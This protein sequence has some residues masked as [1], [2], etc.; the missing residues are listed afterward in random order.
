MDTAKLHFLKK[1]LIPLLKQ[2]PPQMAPRWGKMNVQQMI[3]HFT[4]AVHVAAGT[5]PDVPLITTEEA[6]PKMQAFLESD[7]PFR[8]NTRN[9]LLPQTPCRCGTLQWPMP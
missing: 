7:K 6:L 1:E 5:G 2:I 4:D 8:E 3:E 9:P